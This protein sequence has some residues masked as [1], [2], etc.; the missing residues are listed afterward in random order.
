MAKYYGKVGFELTEETYPGVY[1]PQITEKSYSGDVISDYKRVENSG[2]I[3]DNISINSK[4][5]ILADKF[6]ISNLMNIRYVE[7][8][9]VRWKVTNVEPTLPRIILTA[10]GVYN[11]EQA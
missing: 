6:A 1:E 11:G 10:G 9:G 8:M 3:N 2:D 7:Y 4:F 5:S